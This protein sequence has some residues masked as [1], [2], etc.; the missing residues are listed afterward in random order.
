MGNK[1]E[2][3]ARNENDKCWAFSYSTD[4]FRKFA[5]ML[6]KIK[7]KYQIIDCYIRNFDD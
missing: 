4:S 6:K 2:I 3:I 7:S 5:K 1:Y